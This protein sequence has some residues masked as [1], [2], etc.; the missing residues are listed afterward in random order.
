MPIYQLTDEIIFPPVQGAVDGVVAVGGDLSVER[1][2]LAYRSGIFPWYSDDQPIIWWSPDPRFVLYP[3]SLKISKSMKQVLRNHPFEITYNQDFE[4]V[5]SNCKH[6]TRIGQESTWI[7][8]EMKQAYIKLHKIGLAKSVEVW[9]SDNLIGGLYGIDLGSIFCGESMF[10]NVSNA[11]KVGFITFVQ[12][13]QLH[14]GQLIDCQVYTDHLASLGAEEV[15][16]DRFLAF[17]Q[18]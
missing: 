3:D 10:S 8:D 14:G 17:L 16:R 13:F 1:L 9:Q 4:Q 5:I 7:T 11:S 6:V 18:N 2:E 12:N 15:E